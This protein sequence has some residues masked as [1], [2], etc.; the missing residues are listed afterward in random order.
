MANVSF[1]MDDTLKAQTEDILSQLGLNMT[2]AIT[3]FAKAVVRE[4]GIPFS[5]HV[6]PFYSEANQAILSQTISDFETGRSVPR[7]EITEA[8]AG[9][10]PEEAPNAETQAAMDEYFVM[11]A[12]PE[13]YKRYH[14]FK[15]AM[16][17]VLKDA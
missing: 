5:L 8:S 12:H 3:M 11:Q 9:F 6:D 4:R 13:R 14:T 2:T 15:E 16:D 1:R 7:P 17:E 10:P